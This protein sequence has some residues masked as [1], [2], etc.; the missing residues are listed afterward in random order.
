MNTQ[1]IENVNYFV[2]TK[3]ERK[4]LAPNFSTP[5]FECHCADKSCVGQRI[6]VSLV[7]SLQKL[8]E[9]IKLPL[10]ITSGYRC[11]AHQ[12]ALRASGLETAAGV[13][14]HELG[15]AVDIQ[16][17]PL[18][19]GTMKRLAERAGLYFKA[20]GTAKRFIHVDERSDKI[21]RWTYA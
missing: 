20:I 12:A 9:D 18:D 5:E 10:I 8:A 15:R 17:R 14:Q 3:G 16:P 6:S 1:N 2:W 21:R 13:S 7:A 4:V 11:A 19:G